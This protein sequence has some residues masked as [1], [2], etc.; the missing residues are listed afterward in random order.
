MSKTE[1]NI[2]VNASGIKHL[3]YMVLISDEVELNGCDF[4][5]L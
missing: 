5:Q 1:A 3:G 2:M 4:F